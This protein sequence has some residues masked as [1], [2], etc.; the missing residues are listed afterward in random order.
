MTHGL[1]KQVTSPDSTN[2]KSICYVS[3]LLS[4]AHAEREETQD[5]GC[6]GLGEGN[7]EFMFNGDRV[8][9]G[10]DEKV[11]ERDGGD[12]CTTMRMYLMP[13]NCTLKNG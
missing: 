9:V 2:S 10:E 4:S 8:S 1:L 11:L 13:P 6:Q 12:G 5:G 3:P 7:G